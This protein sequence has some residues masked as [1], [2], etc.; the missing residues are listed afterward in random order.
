VAILAES[1]SAAQCHRGL[2][3][4]YLLLRGAEVLHLVGDNEVQAHQLN[5]HA[6]R[7]S[8]A[9]IYDRR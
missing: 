2:I 8:V 9:L 6:R 5:A 4:D 1:K 7:E 3:S